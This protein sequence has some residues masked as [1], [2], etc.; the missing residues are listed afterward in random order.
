MSLNVWEKSKDLKMNVSEDIEPG[1][2]FSFDKGI[3]DELKNELTNFIDF[4]EENYN[5]PITLLCNFE[6][7][8]YLVGEDGK[9]KGFL[10]Y[11]TDFDNY[12]TFTADNDLPVLFIPVKGYKTKWTLD[13]ILGSFVEGL[14]CYFA[15]LLNQIDEDYY[16]ETL[17]DEILDKYSQSI[18]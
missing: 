15:W 12:P 14:S 18:K 3:D 6:N 8:N 7:K 9:H 13:E 10:F 5:V 2:S 17:V 16:D 1:I 4:V 11:W